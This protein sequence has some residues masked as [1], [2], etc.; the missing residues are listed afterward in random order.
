MKISLFGATGRVGSRVVEYALTEGHT[1]RALV[2]DP[3]KVTPQPHL[4]VMPGDV[5]DPAAVA[6]TLAGADAVISTLGGEGLEKPGAT[7]SQGMR[8]IVAA[9]ATAGVQRVLGVA[10]SGILDSAKGG[11]RLDQPY[12]VAMFRPVTLQHQQAWEAMEGSG[13]EW[14]MACFPDI[15][16]GERTGTYRALDDRLPEK[17]VKISVEDVADFLLRE[18]RARKH[19]Q[20]RVGVA[21]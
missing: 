7:L 13:L 20:H 19:L 1:L 18:L 3:A 15:V 4:E 21:Y 11:L 10:N 16:E 14:T 5:L 17:G 12:F 2:R 8:N 6:R 9:M